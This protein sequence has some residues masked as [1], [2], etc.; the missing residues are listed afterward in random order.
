VVID[1]EEGESADALAF[2]GDELRDGLVRSAGG[3]VAAGSFQ[4]QALSAA[5]CPESRS[6]LGL[7]TV[8]FGLAALGVV[9]T[10][11]VMVA[12]WWGGRRR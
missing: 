7:T 3:D 8:V 4:A 9:G 6:R 2:V 1:G 12:R 11:A 10:Y 5:D